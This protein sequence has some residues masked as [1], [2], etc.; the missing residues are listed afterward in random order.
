MCVCRPKTDRSDMGGGFLPPG[1]AWQAQEGGAGRRTSGRKHQLNDA[2]DDQGNPK[3]QR[4][5]LERMRLQRW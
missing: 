3:D 5:T 4:G 2:H 1:A